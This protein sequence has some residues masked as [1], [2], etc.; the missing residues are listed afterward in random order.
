MAT[1]ILKPFKYQ[2]AF[3]HLVENCTLLY[4]H[5]N[6]YVSLI[7]T[8]QSKVLHLIYAIKVFPEVGQSNCYNNFPLKN[9]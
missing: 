2:I 3:E 8:R 4:Y 6:F 1:Q 5:M 9:Q 7:L